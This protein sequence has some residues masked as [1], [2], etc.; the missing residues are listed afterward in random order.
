MRAQTGAAVIR[1]YD[2]TDAGG[3][4]VARTAGLPGFLGGARYLCGFWLTLP[5]FRPA[6]VRLEADGQAVG[7]GLA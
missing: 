1:G 4:V 6:T 5:G 7:R 3:T 2:E